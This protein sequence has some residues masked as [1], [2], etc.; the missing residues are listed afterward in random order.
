MVFYVIP[1][2]IMESTKPMDTPLTRACWLLQFCRYDLTQLT[3]QELRQLQ[4]EWVD[5]QWGMWKGKR[6]PVRD[7]LI[8]WQQEVRG[9]LD[10]LKNGQRW[11]L[12]CGLWRQLE[13]VNDQLD[14]KARTYPFADG[15]ENKL[16]VKGMDTLEAV[17]NDLR[18]R[19][20]EKCRNLYVRTKRQDYCSV[21]CRGTEGTQR[22]RKKKTNK[23]P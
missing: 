4:S 5:F 18:V 14:A 20:R 3:D 15:A 7:W 23:L 12:D 1:V 8:E 17:S 11:V 2:D 22:Y 9:K 6:P 21:R 10:E 16:L 13:L 19:A